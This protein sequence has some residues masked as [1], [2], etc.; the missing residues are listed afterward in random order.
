MSCY[1]NWSDKQ[2]FR[3]SKR[4]YDRY[5]DTPKFIKI[6]CS[7]SCLLAYPSISYLQKR[8]ATQ[9]SWQSSFPLRHFSWGEII[10]RED[11]WMQQSFS[12]SP[13]LC[14]K[15]VPQGKYPPG[16]ESIFPPKGKFGKSSTQKCW[17]GGDM[18]ATQAGNSHLICVSILFYGK[19]IDIWVRW[20]GTV[21]FSFRLVS[22]GFRMNV[23]VTV[24][25][26]HSTTLA[27]SDVLF[28]LFCEWCLPNLTKTTGFPLIRSSVALGFPTLCQKSR[29][30]FVKIY[31]FQDHGFSKSDS[32]E[33]WASK[34]WLVG[35]Y[36]KLD[37]P[38]K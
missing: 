23:P 3:Y 1:T 5:L 33:P 34:P 35:F 20:W 21:S 16:N 27:S 6:T 31:L 28:T 17:L 26:V 10:T 4:I 32:S 12:H 37:Y 9:G 15:K 14:E 7:K 25:A 2:K 19:F 8:V 38:T 22:T 29:V 13:G 24:W 18:L 11:T 30:C 36:R